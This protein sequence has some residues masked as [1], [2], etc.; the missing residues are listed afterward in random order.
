MPR[1]NPDREAVPGAVSARTIAALKLFDECADRTDIALAD[2]LKVKRPRSPLRDQIMRRIVL[3]FGDGRLKP[4]S[5]YERVCAGF[6]SRTAVQRQIHDLEWLGLIFLR[7]VEGSRSI[8]VI[9]SE[10]LIGWY[11]KMAEELR[12]L[13]RNRL[14]DID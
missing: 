9:P 7:H 5:H 3:C 13:V 10:R 4:I 14:A 2:L 12:S 1:R 8:R 6:G 11:E